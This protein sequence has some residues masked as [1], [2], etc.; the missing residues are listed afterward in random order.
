MSSCP[1]GWKRSTRAGAGLLA[2]L[3]IRWGEALPISKVNAAKLLY[4]FYA[5]TPPES[6]LS[7]RI[8]I[9]KSRTDVLLTF[10]FGSGGWIRTN[11]LRVMSPTSYLCSTPHSN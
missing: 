4:F 3:A 1:A 7:L 10:D 5:D 9:K 6:E 2:A 11:D 8:C